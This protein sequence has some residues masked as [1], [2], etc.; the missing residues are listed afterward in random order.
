M[1][2]LAPLTS[3]LQL[4]SDRVGQAIRPLALAGLVATAVVGAALAPWVMHETVTTVAAALLVA[5]GFAASSRLLWHQRALART[6]GNPA[7]VTDAVHQMATQAPER[8][9]AAAAAVRGVE[10]ASRRRGVA[11]EPSLR[12]RP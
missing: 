4:I 10:A 3:R 5:V 12:C 2:D 1:P 6:L 8:A 7:F 9:R 11:A